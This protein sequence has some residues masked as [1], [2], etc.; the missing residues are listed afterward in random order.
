[1]RQTYKLYLVLML[2]LLTSG[3]CIHAATQQL[4]RVTSNARWQ[5]LTNDP[6]FGYKNEI[7]N[8]PAPS[9]SNFL[10]HT[11]QLITAFF[12]STAGTSLLQ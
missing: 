11:I 5:K 10:L 1:M 3:A 6:A 4:S 2:W 9:G 7:E 12:N 8:P